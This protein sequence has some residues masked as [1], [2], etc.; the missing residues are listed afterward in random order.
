MENDTISLD[1]LHIFLGCEPCDIVLISYENMTSYGA[2]SIFH[3]T[4]WVR[5]STGREKGSRII[6]NILFDYLPVAWVSS[7]EL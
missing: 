6:G 2:L 1:E 7:L 4:S 3:D 5:T